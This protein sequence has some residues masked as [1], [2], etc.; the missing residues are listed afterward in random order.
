[1]IAFKNILT[2]HLDPYY[3]MLN[4]II[5]P[6]RNKHVIAPSSVLYTIPW[7]TQVFPLQQ[8]LNI[9]VSI[10]LTLL[11]EEILFCFLPQFLHHPA[12]LML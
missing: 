3:V 8:F 5:F 6:I 4:E 1:M 2:A 12:L 9:C 7:G 11:G 10:I